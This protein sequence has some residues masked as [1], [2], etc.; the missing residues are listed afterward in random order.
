MQH[1]ESPISIT[2]CGVLITHMASTR[3]SK[4]S[5][6]GKVDGMF[7]KSKETSNSHLH[8]VQ[9]SNSKTV[10]ITVGSVA[11]GLSLMIFIFFARW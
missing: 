8:K 10:G 4:P 2:S 5:D 1:W 7:T 6:C 9:C 3:L 11:G